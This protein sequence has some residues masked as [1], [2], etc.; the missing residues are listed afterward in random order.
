MVSVHNDQPHGFL[1]CELSL[2]IHNTGRKETGFGGEGAVGALVDVEGA[3][4]GQAVE[5]PEG[6]VADGEGVGKEAGVERWGQKNV[7]VE[8][9]HR[10]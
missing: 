1:L 6:S 8:R 9:G 10:T 4:G 7:D 5:K 3:V 2:D